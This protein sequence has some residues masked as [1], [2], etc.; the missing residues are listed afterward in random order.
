M[1]HRIDDLYVA[2][3]LLFEPD[4]ADSD[5]HQ[6]QHTEYLSNAAMSREWRF[7]FATLSSIC[8]SASTKQRLAALGHLKSHGG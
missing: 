1:F 4:F 2:S 8:L 7:V 5:H 3:C 6:L